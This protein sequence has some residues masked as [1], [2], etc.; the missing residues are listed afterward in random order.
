ME[1]STI[2]FTNLKVGLT[3]FIGLVIL[4]IFLFL[5]GTQQ[6]YF[7]NTYELKIFVN[8]TEGLANGS[9]VA[10]GGIKVGNVIDMAFSKRDGENGIEI[11]VKLKEE[12]KSRITDKSKATI[13]SI[14]LLG[15]KFIDVTMGQPD[16]KPLEGGEFIPVNPSFALDKLTEDIQPTLKDFSQVITNLKVITDT[17]VSGKGSVGR[18]I[19]NDYT[20]NEMNNILRNLSLFTSAIVEQ[21]GT[22]GKLTYN[23]V[24]FDNLTTLS[25]NLNEISEDVKSGK[26]SLGKLVTEDSVYN[27]VH[28]LSQ[29]LNNLLAKTESDS[30][31]VGGLLNDKKLY[32]E[33]NGIITNLNNLLIEISNNPK[34]YLKISVF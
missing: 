3:V 26:G 17:V 20:I 12:Y 2:S 8:S 31:V 34:K 14:G 7:T 5:V 18:L 13:K 30:T 16:E 25:S 32:N 22:I 28:K 23:P 33:L 6:N 1:K 27:N 9:M 24:L 19:T 11:T 15:D 4:F 21:K 29:Q 10:V